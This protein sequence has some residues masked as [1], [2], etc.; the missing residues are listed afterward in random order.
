MYLT[1]VWLG[2]IGHREDVFLIEIGL[3][4]Q[5]LLTILGLTEN[6]GLLI[7]ILA[8]LTLKIVATTGDII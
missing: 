7:K 8:L 1:G 2:L 5:N 3:Q 4:V 6:G